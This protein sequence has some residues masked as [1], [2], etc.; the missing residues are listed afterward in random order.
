M[1][2]LNNEVRV[3]SS[4]LP[5]EAALEEKVDKK[6]MLTLVILILSKVNE[7]LGPSRQESFVDDEVPI[8]PEVPNSPLSQL[9]VFYYFFEN[10]ML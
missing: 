9:R 5:L 3:S 6:C 8:S 2:R 1:L 10:I 7:L 4:P